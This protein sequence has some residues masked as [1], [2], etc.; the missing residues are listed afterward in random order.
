[1][2]GLIHRGPT[3]S[4]WLDPSN[5]VQATFLNIGSSSTRGA[6]LT[7]NYRLAVGSAGRLSFSLIGTYVKDFLLQ[8]LPTRAAFDCKGFWGS[9]CQAPLP[10]W[11]HVFN[12]GW[13]TPWKGLEL[14]ARWRYIGSSS[15]DRSSSDPQLAAPFYLATAHIPAYNYVD[16]SAAIPIGSTADIRLGVNNLADKNPP[17]ILNGTLSDCPN[18][19]C[20]DNTWVG[21]YDTLGR[22]I[23]MHVGVKF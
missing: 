14:N 18:T 9:T 1:L 22:Y 11:R 17:L 6:D 8:P 16:L 13:A 3:G 5:F 12:V 10:S 15:V 4:L 7:G 2:C 23:Y 19:T 21:S 20:N